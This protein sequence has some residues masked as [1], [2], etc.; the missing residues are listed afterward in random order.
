MEEVKSLGPASAESF[1]H[2]VPQLL[3]SG[4]LVRPRRLEGLVSGTKDELAGSELRWWGLV[5][6]CEGLCHGDPA[7]LCGGTQGAVYPR[8]RTYW[9]A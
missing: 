7:R 4:E 9:G 3:L 2:P 5:R 1:L 8:W 6:S